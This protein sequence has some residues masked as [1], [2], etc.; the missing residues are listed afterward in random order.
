MKSSSIQSF[1]EMF[2]IRGLEN[3]EQ[4]L[5]EAVRVV[6]VFRHI[7]N[8]GVV[9]SDSV[10]DK[11]RLFQEMKRLSEESKL[12]HFPG[13]RDFFYNLFSVADKLDLLEL[14][15]AVNKNERAGIMLAP[16][17][18]VDYLAGGFTDAQDNILIA[19]AE[20]MAERLYNLIKTNPDKMFTLTTEKYVI[21]ILLTTVFADFKNV[22]VVNQ[23]IYRELLLEENFDMAICIPSFGSRL[24]PE[25]TGKSFLTRDSECIAIENLIKLINDEGR[26]I[27]VTPAKVTFAGGPVQEFRKWLLENYNIDSIYSLPEGTFRPYAG[28]KTY[29]IAFSK[30]RTDG[31]SIGSIED[32][33]YQLV[34]KQKHMISYDEFEQHDDW[35]IELFLAD[36][37][38]TIQRFKTSRLEK[39]KLKE[40]AEVFRGK[41]VLKD[42]IQ[43]GKIFVLNISNIE[44]GEVL[45]DGMDTIHEEERKIKRYQLIKNDI[46]LTCRGTANKVAIFPE[47]ERIVIA[48]A[49]VIVARLSEKVLPLYLKIFLESPIG[50]M[51]VKS[52]QRG[53]TVMNINPNDLGELEIPLLPLEKQHQLAA[54]FDEEYR[55]YRQE[56]AEI[57]QRWERERLGIYNHFLE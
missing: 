57:E 31:V 39:V 23:S 55:R 42:D 2:Y 53:T 7:R 12:G 44:D 34:L 52:F 24:S 30:S 49:N 15:V 37:N 13:D 8:K 6:L 16:D 45:L 26:L 35:R 40:V 11:E 36:D 28:I 27:V 10:E 46:I 5:L 41:S 29:L 33:Q 4:I 22:R 38:E 51:L 56:L 43:P 17:Y 47:T 20:K 48:S 21:Y 9:L 54:R 3:K 32:E 19:E 25:D 14:L 50:Q 18:L 1:W